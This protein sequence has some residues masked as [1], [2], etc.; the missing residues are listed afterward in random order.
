[1]LTITDRALKVLRTVTGHP[2]LAEAIW[3]PHCAEEP[4]Q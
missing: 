4:D 2:R 3:T 1:M